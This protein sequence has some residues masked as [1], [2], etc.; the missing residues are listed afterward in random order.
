MSFPPFATAIEIIYIHI[1]VGLF[2]TIHF[3]L[4]HSGMKG[5]EFVEQLIAKVM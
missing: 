5:N 4:R 1:I 3:K 2:I